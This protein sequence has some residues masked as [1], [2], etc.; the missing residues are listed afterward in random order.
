M[1]GTTIKKLYNEVLRACIH[2][3]LRGGRCILNIL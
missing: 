1:H 3:R 2:Q